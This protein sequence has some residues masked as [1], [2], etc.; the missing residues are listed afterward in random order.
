MTE[1]EFEEL[2]ALAQRGVLLSDT[3]APQSVEDAL[4]AVVQAEGDGVAP[5]VAEARRI[6]ATP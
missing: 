6:F 3:G 1:P 2:L 4:F 5:A